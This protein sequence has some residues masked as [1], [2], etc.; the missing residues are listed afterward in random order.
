[1]T[2]KKNEEDI[3]RKCEFLEAEV[4]RQRVSRNELESRLVKLQADNDMLIV[5]IKTENERRMLDFNE[6]FEKEALVIK[7][8]EEIKKEREMLADKQRLLRGYISQLS[9][10]ENI[11]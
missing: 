4:E 1:M 5:K 8:R 9:R 3:K 2:K 11:R 10:G 7:E 6:F